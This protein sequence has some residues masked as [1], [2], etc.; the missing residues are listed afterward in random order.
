MSSHEASIKIDL[1]SFVCGFSIHFFSILFIFRIFG[2]LVQFVQ[3]GG[4]SGC[5]V[6]EYVR[7]IRI[8]VRSLCIEN[9]FREAEEWIN[10]TRDVL[11]K[12]SR[13]SRKSP[14]EVQVSIAIAC[15]DLVQAQYSV[16]LYHSRVL[17]RSISLQ[18]PQLGTFTNLKVE[19][20]NEKH[21]DIVRDILFL[22]EFFLLLLH[23]SSPLG[24]F[25][26]VQ[27]LEN[28][29]SQASSASSTLEKYVPTLVFLRDTAPLFFEILD[30][31]KSYSVSV[32]DIREVC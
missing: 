12:L 3:E 25:W 11:T 14:A 32:E 26:S 2:Y 6:A 10:D 23:L 22:R 27:F 13:H 19:L 8:L 18:E 30:L 15:I 17:T 21:C 9:R 1:T 24:I 16:A 4:R 5:T 29:L 7:I 20:D 28:A 31:K